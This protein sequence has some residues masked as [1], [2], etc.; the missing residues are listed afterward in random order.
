MRHSHL[1][2]NAEGHV[3]WRGDTLMTG[4]WDNAALTQQ[5][6]TADGLVTNDLG[7][8]D[9]AG[10]LC[11][12]GRGDDVINV[13]GYKVAPTEVEE[14]VLA[15]GMVRDCIS[16]PF[17]HPVIGTVVQLLVVIAPQTNFSKRALLLWLKERL[18]AYKIPQRIEEIDHIERT[19]NGKLNRKHYAPY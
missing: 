18:E 8:I 5:L 1:H 17:V 16:T 3:V 9:V 15:S 2:I 11:L 14:Q 13:G 12:Q 10:R 7:I 4:Y 6:L 19:N